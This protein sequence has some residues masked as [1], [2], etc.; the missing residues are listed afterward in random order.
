MYISGLMTPVFEQPLSLPLYIYLYDLHLYGPI[1][2]HDAFSTIFL[3]PRSHLIIYVKMRQ[4]DLQEHFK[5]DRSYFQSGSPTVSH[6]RHVWRKGPQYQSLHTDLNSVWVS[7]LLNADGILKF[8][9]NPFV[10]PWHYENAQFV[11]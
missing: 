11:L 7:F 10:P 4:R 1:S 3:N 2:M 8:P 6:T 9:P 5:S